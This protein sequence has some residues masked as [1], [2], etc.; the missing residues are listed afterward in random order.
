M[1]R[2]TSFTVDEDKIVLHPLDEV[3]LEAPF[4]N[5]VEEVR[6]NK[7]VHVCTWKR[8]CKGLESMR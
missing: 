6:S 7:L 4:D 5:L 3:V 2:S 1:A 8:V